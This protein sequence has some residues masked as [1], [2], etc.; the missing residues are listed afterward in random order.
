MKCG[1]PVLA[2]LLIVRSAFAL[3]PHEILLL[4]NGRSPDSIEIGKAYAEL[5]GVPE[6]NVVRLALPFETEDWNHTVDHEAFTRSIWKP[7]TRIMKKRGLEGQILAWV[8]SVDFPI[9]LSTATPI[10]IQGITF[11]RNR[12]PDPGDVR[13]ATYHSPLFAGPSSRQGLP[14]RTQTFDRYKVW[15]REDMP[16]PSMMLG[17]RGKNGNT[18][19]E[20]RRCLNRGA[21]SDGTRPSGTVYF[22][23]S[24]DVRSK[25]RQWQLRG[26][27]DD[28]TKLGLSVVIGHGKPAPLQDVIGLQMGT[29]NVKTDRH[30]FLPGA[31]AEHLTSAAAVFHQDHQTKLTSWIRAGATAS[32]GTVSE[33]YAIWEKFP[34]AH[35][36]YHYASGATMIESFYQSIKSPLQ[37]LL[38]GDPLASPWGAPEVSMSL[39]GTD[40]LGILEIT[41]ARP[42]VHTSALEFWAARF[43]YLVD[44]RF[45]H[46]G[47]SV[48]IERASFTPGRHLLRTIAQSAGLV[49][50]QAYHDH[51][52]TVP[53]R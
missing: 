18:L 49:G 19:A 36:Y 38:V 20:I 50:H 35:F 53:P 44:G 52:F 31:M 16:L 34:T 2:C 23:Q 33:P 25:C 7:A 6:S 40:G 26:A 10:S 43:I 51:A 21:A 5:R 4:V 22:I 13:H 42:V 32:C 27:N 48:V 46:E 15:L 9:R 30:T 3:G 41:A 37:I 45:I 14:H 29:P 28:L 11:L 8:Y 47:H 39:E 17:H 1:F 24:E 12:L